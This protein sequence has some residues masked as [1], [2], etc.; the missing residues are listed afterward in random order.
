MQVLGT[1]SVQFGYIH[2][3]GTNNLDPGRPEQQSHQL[4]P[5]RGTAQIFPAIAK[6][7]YGFINGNEG[8]PAMNL[9]QQ[10]LG[11]IG[12][13]TWVQGNTLFC[14]MIL[15][16]NDTTA[17]CVAQVDVNVLYLG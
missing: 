3:G 12:A 1:D 11:Q 9:N 5:P 6:M 16:Q 15:T 14:W 13:Q 17:P 10:P 2:Y 8:S 4:N 7:N